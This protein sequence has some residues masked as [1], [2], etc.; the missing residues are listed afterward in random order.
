MLYNQEKKI[1]TLSHE[2]KKNLYV[3]KETL[4]FLFYASMYAPFEVFYM[5][6]KQTLNIIFTFSFFKWEKWFVHL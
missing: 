6:Q 4:F 1:N 5:S 3:G 2:S